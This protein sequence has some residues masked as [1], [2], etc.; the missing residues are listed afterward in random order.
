MSLDISVQADAKRYTFVLTHALIYQKQ[1]AQSHILMVSR[2]S[3]W[4]L[5]R[6]ISLLFG[7]QVYISAPKCPRNWSQILC[8]KFIVHTVLCVCPLFIHVN[9]PSVSVHYIA[10]LHP[11]ML[12]SALAS[13]K[14]RAALERNCIQCTHIDVPSDNWESHTVTNCE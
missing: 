1:P 10:L 14:D 8:S 5:E 2:W 12:P 6:G 11:V 7:P 4:S 13:Q 9:K 3:Y